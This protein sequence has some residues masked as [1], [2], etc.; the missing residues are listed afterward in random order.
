MSSPRPADIDSIQPDF[1]L[2][3]L[4]VLYALSVRLSASLLSSTLFAFSEKQSRKLRKL[5]PFLS[6]NPFRSF[7]LF[8]TLAKINLVFV[9]TSEKHPGY[10]A[11]PPQLL[12]HYLK[13]ARGAPSENSQHSTGD[14]RL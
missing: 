1:C 4:R 2:P 3:G 5:T 14:S 7:S 8:V 11:L 9:T 13:A 12:N 10:T 6:T